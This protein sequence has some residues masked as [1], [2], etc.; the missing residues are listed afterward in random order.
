M[1]SELIEAVAVITPPKH[2]GTRRAIRRARD[3]MRSRYGLR[4]IIIPEKYRV[5]TTHDVVITYSSCLA[6]VYF[7]ANE[8][9]LMLSDILADPKRSQLYSGLLAHA[10]IGL[11]LTLTPEGVHA[12][13]PFGKS[14]IDG[15][16]LRVLEGQN[17]I[18][19]YGTAR[20]VLNAIE[21]LVRQS[22]AGDCVLFGAY[23]G[24][25][26]ISF[27][28]Q[29]GAHGSAGGDQV[30]PFIIAPSWLGLSRERLEDARDIHRAVLLR[31]T[32][33]SERIEG[34]PLSIES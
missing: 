13:S 28:D 21:S 3:W 12:E 33:G 14:L 11:V 10:G 20:Y 26:I 27:D 7:A 23:D 29:V 31:Y 9:R 19:P 8:Q 32:A 25:E 2:Q 5:A 16:I 18:E 34:N 4:D 22:N 30:H 15:G 24:Y 1:G 6:L 17:P